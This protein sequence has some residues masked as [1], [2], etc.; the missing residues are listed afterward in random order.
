MLENGEPPTSKVFYSATYRGDKVTSKRR[1]VTKKR[2]ISESS[3]GVWNAT[4]QKGPNQKAL[5]ERDAESAV[6]NGLQKDKGDFLQPMKTH[7]KANYK[8]GP[9]K[10]L[11]PRTTNQVRDTIIIFLRA[12]Y[13]VALVHTSSSLLNTV[14]PWGEIKNQKIWPEI[15]FI[16]N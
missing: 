3:S 15:S 11:I 10:F 2:G 7:K 12:R 13:Q 8:Q 6:Q 9:G 16:R 5:D 1:H 4:G 14:L